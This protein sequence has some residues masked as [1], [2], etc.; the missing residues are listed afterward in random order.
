MAKENTVSAV[1]EAQ[2]TEISVLS[3]P[4]GDDYLSLTDIARFRNADD[5]NGVVANW[6]RNRNTIEYLG[7]WETLNNPDFK[8]LEFEG[9]RVASGENA[10]TLS[11]TKWVKSTQAIGMMVKS[12]RG[13]GTFAHKDIAF[14][15]AAWISPEFELYII[16]DYQRLK[17]SERHQLALDWSVKRYLTKINYRFHTDAIK[18]HL[19][20]AALTKAQEGYV[21]AD[22]ADM[23]NVALFGKTAKAW[24]AEKPDR[25]GKNMR[26]EATIEQLIVLANLEQA[27]SLLIEQ[28]KTQR[29]RIITLRQLAV[30]QLQRIAASKSVNELNQMNDQLRLPGASE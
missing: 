3:V 26:D 2:G 25:K 27:N 7:L 6:M 28:G 30:S 22:E 11:P 8:P 9:F 20:P 29:E 13:G 15:F 5:P 10:F 14:K 21:Y 18:A 24:R 12:G 23:L 19:I 1:I 4:D 16:K 17:Q